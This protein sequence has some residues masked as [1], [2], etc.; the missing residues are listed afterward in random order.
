[1]VNSAK[2]DPA[3]KGMG[4]NAWQEHKLADLPAGITK[5]FAP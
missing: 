4:K 1:V 2:N 5:G 3:R